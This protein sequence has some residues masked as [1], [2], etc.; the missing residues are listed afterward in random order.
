M[1]GY[2]VLFKDVNYS[3]VLKVIEL[4]IYR[5]N[6]LRRWKGRNKEIQYLEESFVFVVVFLGY[7]RELQ[8]YFSDFESIRRIGSGVLLSDQKL[9]KLKVE[10]LG[11]FSSKVVQRG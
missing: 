7:L 4:D 9:E 11:N 5:I 8:K 10:E 1:L 2:E 3:I 6:I